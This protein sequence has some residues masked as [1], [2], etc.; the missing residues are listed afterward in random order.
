MRVHVLDAEASITDHL[1]EHPMVLSS[2]TITHLPEL[3]VRLRVTDGSVVSEGIGAVNLSA[4]WAWPDPDVRFEHKDA[5]MRSYGERVAASAAERTGAPAHP[6][7][8][9]LRLHDTV[10]ADSDDHGPALARSVC[11]SAVDAA[12]HD[13]AGRL[14]GV[15]AFSLYDEDVAV[16]GVDDQFTDGVIAAVRDVLRPPAESLAGWWAYA[17]GD[18]L[19]LL[20]QA[21][22]RH[23][24]GRF[25]I[26]LSGADPAADAVRVH[27]A[28]TRAGELVRSPVLSIDTNEGSPSVAAVADFLAALA[29]LDPA[30]VTAISHLEQ[31]TPRDSLAVHDW[32]DVADRVPVLLDEGLTSLADLPVAAEK[33]WSGLALKTC[34]GHSFVL[35]A[36]AWA[37]QHQM[38]LSVQDLTNIGRSAIHSWL[39]AAHLDG[40]DSVE[41]NS[42]QY[43]P[44]ANE[45]WLPRLASLFA[46]RDGH[47]RLA[48]RDLMGLG[49]D[50]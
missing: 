45:P 49:S 7:E 35:A 29:S 1:M 11:A 24:M 38:S 10:L 16:P 14:A 48:H 43:L 12:L 47:H 32:H 37:K 20:E 46:I 50:M 4:I 3:T 41:L 19:S 27:Q 15:S 40:V 6:L 21:V 39:F 33:G 44:R 22:R 30:A 8:L 2:G 26:K 28:W 9:G 25:K 23:G 18:D 34:K 17:P 42:P 5:V 13:A 31:P 36:A